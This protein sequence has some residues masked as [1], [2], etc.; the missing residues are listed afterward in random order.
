MPK[1]QI[2]GIFLGDDRALV[3]GQLGA[4]GR[5]GQ[6]R[7]FHHVLRDG[8]D[9]R[10]VA[11]GLHED[12][13]VVVA[14]RGRHVHLDREAQVFLQQPVV[15]VLDALE[16]RHAR[17]VDVVGL[18]IEDGEFL[19]LAHDLAQVGIA[20]GGLADRLCPE[21]RQEIVAQVVILKRRFRHVAQIDAVNVGQKDVAGRPHDAHVVL[22]VQRDLKIVAPV[23]ALHGRCPAE[24]GR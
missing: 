20:V 17:I 10:I 3:L 24:P 14:R 1:L 11:H 5:I 22:D 16:P 12:R 13:A 23:A 8:L 19:N 21:R 18:V 9:Q 4:A 6:H 15:N 2:V 7:M